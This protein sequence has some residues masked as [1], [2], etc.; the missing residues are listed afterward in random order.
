MRTVLSSKMYLK[1]KNCKI[2][3]LE[4]DN[5]QSAKHIA[6]LKAKIIAQDKA[7]ET[8]MDKLREKFD[9]AN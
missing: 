8:E 7:H 5:S 4:S 1:R 9:E 3:E 6:D 2:L